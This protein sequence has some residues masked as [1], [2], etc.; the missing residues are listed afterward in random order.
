[1][2]SINVCIYTE[3]NTLNSLCILQF[4]KFEYFIYLFLDKWK[5]VFFFKTKENINLSL[6]EKHSLHTLNWVLFMLFEAVLQ[7]IDLKVNIIDVSYSFFK[8]KK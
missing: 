3:S 1:M 8:Y 5:N 4:L 2:F 6:E 7:N